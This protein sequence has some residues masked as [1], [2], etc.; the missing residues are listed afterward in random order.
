MAEQVLLPGMSANQLC[1]HARKL[2]ATLPGHEKNT[3]G[4]SGR[5]KKRQRGGG[6][7]YKLSVLRQELFEWFLTRRASTSSRLP[8]SELVTQARMLRDAI[9]ATALKR[10]VR[11]NVP[12][13][14]RMWFLRWRREYQVSLRLPNRRWKVKAWILH[15]RLAITWLNVIR[16][17]RLCYLAF[18]YEPVVEGF[19][20]NQ[21]T[22]TR[23]EVIK[24]RRSVGR[25][26]ARYH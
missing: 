2:A 14:N 20:E 9:I 17:R 16:L 12:V 7:H 4:K 26:V 3:H 19:D 25:V 23:A 10:K 21:C 8:L 18:G 15:E 6:R 11:V 22:S 1:K 24:E 13:L 5:E